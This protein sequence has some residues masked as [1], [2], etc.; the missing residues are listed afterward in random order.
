MVQSTSQV[1]LSV[2]PD[3]PTDYAYVPTRQEVRQAPA[4]PSDMSGRHDPMADLIRSN[5][6]AN[7]VSPATREPVQQKSAAPATKSYGATDR[8][9]LEKLIE[10]GGNRAR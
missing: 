2:V 7:R 6:A 9:G 1:L 3:G 8:Q 5:G 4:Q 10:T